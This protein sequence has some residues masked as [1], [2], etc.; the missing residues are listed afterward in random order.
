MKHKH[1]L[2]NSRNH[3]ETQLR[4]LIAHQHLDPRSKDATQA[5]T[6]LDEIKPH[7][8]VSRLSE[9]RF[10]Q[11]GEQLNEVAAILKRYSPDEEE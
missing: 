9:A 1:N 11:L 8:A 7:V 2:A 10:E 3:L 4:D 5:R 6:A